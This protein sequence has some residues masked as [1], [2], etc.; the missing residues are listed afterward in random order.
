MGKVKW[1][2]DVSVKCI[3]YRQSEK[4]KRFLNDK[5]VRQKKLTG[6]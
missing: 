1:A 3:K 4:G 5:E 6:I 2:E